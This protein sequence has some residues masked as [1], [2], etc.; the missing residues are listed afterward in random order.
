MN[1]IEK[2]IE[3]ALGSLDYTRNRVLSLVRLATILQGIDLEGVSSVD[4]YGDSFNLYLDSEHKNSKLPHI[5]AQKLGI[6]F[7]KEKNWDNSSIIYKGVMEDGITINIYGAVPDTCRVEYTEVP[8]PEE[9][10]I[11]TRKVANIICNEEETVA[12]NKDN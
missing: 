5:L 1:Q 8:I 7:S 2:A 3:E 12:T 10:I 9:E 4:G 11:R 6:N